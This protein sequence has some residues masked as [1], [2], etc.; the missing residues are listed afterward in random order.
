MRFQDKP[1]VGVIVNDVE[2]ANVLLDHIE[3][4]CDKLGYNVIGSITQQKH[5][6]ELFVAC[7][8]SGDRW[9]DTITLIKDLG[10]KFEAGELEDGFGLIN[11][12]NPEHWVWEDTTTL[13]E[14]Q[15]FAKHW[16]FA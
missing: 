15:K 5:H 3:E 7:F 4:E 8:V 16:V 13:A 14:A 1:Y 11:P 10:K 6:E 12:E 9:F 2:G